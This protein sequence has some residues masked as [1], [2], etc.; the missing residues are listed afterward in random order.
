MCDPA[1][2]GEGEA[3]WQAAP[4]RQLL[5]TADTRLCVL[6]CIC[7]LFTWPVNSKTGRSHWWP[8]QHFSV[9]RDVLRYEVLP[10]LDHNAER[11]AFVSSSLDTG[12]RDD[13]VQWQATVLTYEA[14]GSAHVC[15]L[16]FRLSHC[17]GDGTALFDLLLSVAQPVSSSTQQQQQQPRH[18]I[19]SS[20]TMS[21]GPVTRVL[22]SM[23][24]W[25]RSLALIFHGVNK[26]LTLP[27]QSR[28]PKSSLRVAEGAATAKKQAVHRVMPLQ[29][30]KACQDQQ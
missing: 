18:V 26:I 17:V 20:S 19:S 16:V 25:L 11:L 10:G 2:D 5:L 12:F 30:L 7:L 21:R 13:E 24:Q 1:V 9:E 3:A 8:L 15:D 4:A 14:A 6:M 29:R 27:M 23:W 28:D 22:C